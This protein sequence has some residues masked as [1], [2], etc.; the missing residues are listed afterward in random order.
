MWPEQRPVPT[1]QLRNG[2]WRGFWQRDWPLVTA[3]NCTWPC[4]RQRLV[5]LTAMNGKVLGEKGA[6]WS[7]VKTQQ[8]E[9]ALPL[10]WS[11]LTPNVE[12]PV[13]IPSADGKEFL[14][15]FDALSMN[16]TCKTSEG[17]G[18]VGNQCWSTS[19][20]N[21]IGVAWS[22]DGERWE[23]AEHVVHKDPYIRIPK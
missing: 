6:R 16:E 3:L 18:W 12:N 21:S 9:E 19:S 8:V 14:M 2:S 20:C 10:V 4:H 17:C 13:V 22:S 23:H 1:F 11:E 5:G 15:V 7:V